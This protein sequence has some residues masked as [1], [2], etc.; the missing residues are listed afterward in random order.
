MRWL[1]PLALWT[2]VCVPVRAQDVSLL[3]SGSDLQKAAGVYSRNLK[4]LW[5]EDF[6]LRL[7]QDER[8][9]A[10]NI[11]LNLPL[12]GEN[13]SPLDFY[14]IAAQRQV[15]LPIASV[16]FLD[17]LSVAF[18]Y[19]NRMGCDQGI[20]SDYAAVLRIRPQDAKGSPF[21][22]LGVPGTALNDPYVNDVSQKI[23]K[24]SVYFAAAHEYAHVMYHHKPYNT[25]TAQQ[26]Q[27]QEIEADAFALEVMRRIG[28]VPLGM[29]YFFLIA[30][31]LEPTPAD[32]PSAAEYENYLHQRATHPVSA[33]RIL[34]IADEIESDTDAFVRSEKNPASTKLILQAMV[35]QLRKI[36]QTLDDPKMRIFLEQKAVKA[37]VVG[38]RRA[39]R[40]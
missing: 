1:L 24:S 28:L 29:T 16:K 35:P 5:E 40:H 38:F 9:R 37:D 19:Y 15:F 20:V 36:A 23:L 4:G 31:R 26:A 10:G 22:T 2:V 32:F 30:S 12:M 14:S 18:V 25:I 27:K 8:R 3:Y 21:D 39:C 7:T 34:T 33:M 11:T 13:K 6:L 17:D